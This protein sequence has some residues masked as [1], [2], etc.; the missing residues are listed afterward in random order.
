MTSVR[1]LLLAMADYANKFEAHSP[2][3]CAAQIE[4]ASLMSEARMFI[5]RGVCNR[6]DS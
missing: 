5:W 4:A 6:Q 1:M 2:E 3:R